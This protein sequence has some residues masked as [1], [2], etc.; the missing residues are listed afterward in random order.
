MY[1]LWVNVYSIP[2]PIFS[3]FFLKIVSLF[4]YYFWLCWVSVAVRR[5]SLFAAGGG[6]S[7][8]A[9]CR[10]PIVVSS[11]VEHGL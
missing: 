1:L 3:S 6:Y 11:L 4:V 9:V 2:L 10:L 8:V 7:L 5:L